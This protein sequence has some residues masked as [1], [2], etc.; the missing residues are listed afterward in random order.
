[1][2]IPFGFSCDGFINTLGSLSNILI[3]VRLITGR[4]WSGYN[5]LMANLPDARPIHGPGCTGC[6]AE[7]GVTAI[8]AVPA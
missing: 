4:E 1:M 2:H 6:R 3:D 5:F 8:S 7:T